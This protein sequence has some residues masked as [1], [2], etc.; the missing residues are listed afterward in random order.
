VV[1]TAISVAAVVAVVVQ[2]AAQQ[3]VVYQAR[4]QV[5]EDQQASKK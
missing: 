1:K 5:A 4:V 2:V 3:N